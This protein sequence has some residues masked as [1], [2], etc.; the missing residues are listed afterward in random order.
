MHLNSYVTHLE[1]ANIMFSATTGICSVVYATRYLENK[2]K[3][4]PEAA[5]QFV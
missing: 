5:V 2:K 1:T 4:I 3:R